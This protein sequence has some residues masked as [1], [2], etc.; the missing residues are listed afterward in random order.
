MDAIAAQIVPSGDSPGAREA[1]ALHFIDH[2]LA[3]WAQNQR[4]QITRGL[5]DLNR[6]VNERWP[7]TGHFASLLAERQVELLHAVERTPFFQQVRFAVIAGTFAN[8]AW[9]GN[10]DGLGWQILGFE[11]RFVWQP[12][13][14]DYDADEMRR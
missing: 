5:E 14:G 3:T 13:F 10:K 7:G 4:D 2:S 12:P 6:Q 11:P 8:P 9:G 1:G